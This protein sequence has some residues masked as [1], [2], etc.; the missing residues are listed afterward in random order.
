MP[1]G[2]FAPSPTGRLHLGNLRTALLAWLFARSTDSAFLLRIEDLD[3]AAARP[4]H[5]DSQP[6]DLAAIGLDW[7]G[8]ITLQSE[9]RAMHDAAIDRLTADGLTFP[10]YCTRKE[11]HEAAQAPHG[12]PPGAYPGT[13]RDLTAAD[14]AAREADGRR[15]ALRLRA[16]EQQVTIHDRFHGEHTGT[17]DDLVLRRADG[18]PAYNLAVVVDDADQ[19]VEEVVRADDLLTSTPRQ[20]HLAD[21]LGLRRPTWAH[22]PLAVGP[23]GERLAKRHGAVSL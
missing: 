1:S 4:E 23:D 15:P 13:C 7:D 5:Y 19:G 17:V 20:A 22:V 11:V 3:V 10:C 9:R 16:A 12:G 8:P 14:R 21:L 18:T 6:G 2:R